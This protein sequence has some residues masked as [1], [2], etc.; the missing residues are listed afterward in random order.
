[1]IKK[2]QAMNETLKGADVGAIASFD[3]D[4]NVV[5]G[6]GPIG[7]IAAVTYSDGIA[8]IDYDNGAKI[9]I[10]IQAGDGISVDANESGDG[11]SVR[12]DVS[13]DIGLTFTDSDKWSNISVV[14]IANFISLQGDVTG[15]IYT[16]SVLATFDKKYAP[17][18]VVR[19]LGQCES[20]TGAPSPIISGNKITTLAPVGTGVG[21]LSFNIIW[22]FDAT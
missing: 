21:P 4:G 17:K 2:R 18:Q 3:R 15:P 19:G 12:L 14:R 9:D 6:G 10:P 13:N 11:I 7:D 22:T 20:T 8:H 5:G 1:M 16:A